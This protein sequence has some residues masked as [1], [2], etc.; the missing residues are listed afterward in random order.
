MRKSH[1][2]RLAISP[3]EPFSISN[4]L[5]LREQSPPFYNFSY[6]ISLKNGGDLC[7]HRAGGASTYRFVCALAQSAL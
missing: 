1:G 5:I 6:I 2:A 7:A 4:I 3:G